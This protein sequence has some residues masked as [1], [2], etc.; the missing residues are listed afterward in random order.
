MYNEVN[1]LVFSLLKKKERKKHMPLNTYISLHGISFA[2]GA[3]ESGETELVNLINDASQKN[4]EHGPPW[5]DSRNC[6][7]DG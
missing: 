6:P 7:R 1:P 3:D 5:R 4:P 2:D